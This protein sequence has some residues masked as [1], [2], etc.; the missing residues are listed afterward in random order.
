MNNTDRLYS[1]LSSSPSSLSAPW[2]LNLQVTCPTRNIL[3]NDTYKELTKKRVNNVL[4][5]VSIVE[6]ES[7][8]GGVT[9]E[10]EIQWDGN[11]SIVLDVNTRFGVGLPIQVL[12]SP[13]CQIDLLILDWL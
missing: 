4:T 7:E 3:S 8:S 1:L 2:L 10:L 9:M 6:G 11:P 12:I 5:G 13:S